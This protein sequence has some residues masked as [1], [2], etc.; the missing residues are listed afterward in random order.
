MAATAR[1]L[2][3]IPVDQIPWGVLGNLK[4]SYLCRHCILRHFTTRIRH[5]GV[6]SGKISAFACLSPLQGGLTRQPHSGF[7]IP[8]KMRMFRKHILTK[9]FTEPGFQR[10]KTFPTNHMIYPPWNHYN[11]LAPVWPL[12]VHM[13]IHWRCFGDMDR[14]N[15]C[16]RCNH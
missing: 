4:I 5:R 2:L 14:C 8:D 9:M 11:R 16:N 13:A 1:V 3:W 12:S 15:R 6:P 7:R 10:F